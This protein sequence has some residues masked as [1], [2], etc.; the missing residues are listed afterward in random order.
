MNGILY[1]IFFAV[2]FYYAFKF[3][4][5]LLLPWAMKK[6]AQRMM[7]KTQEGPYT[8]TYTNSNQNPFG[9]NNPFGSYQQQ[10]AQQK[11]DGNVQVE[12]IPQK[13]ENRKG[14]QTAGEFVDFEEIK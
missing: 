7:K 6:L 10:S 9:R 8:Y 12:Y 3:S 1:F 13:E 4:M 11:S 14:T 5:R 2:I